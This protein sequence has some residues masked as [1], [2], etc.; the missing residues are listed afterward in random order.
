MMQ[1]TIM[2]EKEYVYISG[3]WHTKALIKNKQIDDRTA[4]ATP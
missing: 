2:L 1:S 3:N 4:N